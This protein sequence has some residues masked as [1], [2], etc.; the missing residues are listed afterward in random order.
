M[1]G[2]GGEG[3]REKSTEKK[4]TRAAR[5]PTLSKERRSLPDQDRGEE[6]RRGRLVK[7]RRSVPVESVVL[8]EPLLPLLAYACVLRVPDLLCLRYA[9]VLVG[10]VDDTRSEAATAEACARREKG[11]GA[12]GGRG[13]GKRRKKRSDARGGRGRGGSREVERG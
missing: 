10:G 9:V 3:E 1:E 7:K 6:R 8:L 5:H 13:R 11:G 2:G 12:R 4:N